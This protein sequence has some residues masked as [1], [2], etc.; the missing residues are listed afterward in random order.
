MLAGIMLIRYVLRKPFDAP[1][2]FSQIRHFG[3]FL[4]D[5][6][7]IHGLVRIPAQVNTP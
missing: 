4:Y 5:G 2:R 7:V 3:Y 6:R 1:E